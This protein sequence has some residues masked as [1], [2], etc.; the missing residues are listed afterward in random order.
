MN[1]EKEKERERGL[2]YGDKE[3]KNESGIIGITN[4]GE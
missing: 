3:K 1:E 4:N 2:T